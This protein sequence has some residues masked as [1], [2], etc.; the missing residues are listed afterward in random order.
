VY[1][2][3]RLYMRRSL[4][5]HAQCCAATPRWFT[6]AIPGVRSVPPVV[7]PGEDDGSVGVLHG[8]DFLLGHYR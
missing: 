8:G 1:W 2:R 4:V 6:R 3:K 5:R 7:R